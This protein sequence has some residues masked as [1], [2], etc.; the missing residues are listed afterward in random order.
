LSS[1]SNLSLAISR[2]GIPAS[3]A[4]AVIVISGA[5]VASLALPASAATPTAVVPAAAPVA[6]S[7]AVT[8]APSA[9]QAPL[10]PRTFGKIA[11]TG[12]VKPK[13][14]AAPVVHLRAGVAVSRSTT[15]TATSPTTTPTS[16]RTET[17]VVEAPSSS[18]VLGIAASLA[19][20]Y[21]VYGGES[22]AGFDCSGYT[23]Y[24]FAKVGIN[25]P[26]T[27]E[28]Q[29]QAVRSVSDPRP[30]DLV[31][32]GSP[33]YHVGIYAGNGMMWDSPSTG[34]AIALRAIWSSSPTYGR[35]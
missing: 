31:F 13:P 23:Q 8:A 27:A 7:V 20:I 9:A 25:L 3:K 16:A 11:F 24:V 28:E 30:G 12:V 15:R 34:S 18:G 29:R 17:P 14:V 21:Y 19:G 33:A 10:V 6:L 22:T 35:P 4:S 32:F 5:M 1:A 2:S 26:R